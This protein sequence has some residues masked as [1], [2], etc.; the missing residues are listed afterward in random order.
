MLFEH[1]ERAMKQLKRKRVL[2]KKEMLT[3]LEAGHLKFDGYY[4]QN[5]NIR[6]HTCD[7]YNACTLEQVSIL[8]YR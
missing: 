5:D 1:L 4:S 6:G 3:A 7:P 8:S 2:W